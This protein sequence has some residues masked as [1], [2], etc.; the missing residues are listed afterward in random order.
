MLLTTCTFLTPI[1]RFCFNKL[2]FG[3]NSAPEHFQRKMN[4]LLADIPG[5]LVHVDDILI[6]ATT[7]DVHDQ[8]LH[9]VLK[10]I[11]NEGLTLNKDKCKFHQ[12]RIE[13]LGHIIDSEGISP[14]PKR[15][16]AIRKMPLLASLTEL[17]RFMG[18]VN[19][20]NKFFLSQN[21]RIVSAIAQTPQPKTA[22]HMDTEPE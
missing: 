2:P 3:I 4:E 8:R 5:V 20:L 17:R 15:T 13:Y 12:S 6:F 11:Q 10:R 19:Q 22:L 21:C 16:E 9:E 18:I 14:D 7:R 1:G